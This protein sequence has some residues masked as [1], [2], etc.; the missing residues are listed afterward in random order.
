MEEGL[1]EEEE[2]SR[3]Q[4]RLEKVRLMLANKVSKFDPKARFLRYTFLVKAAKTTNAN[5]LNAVFQ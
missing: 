5:L 3:S 4:Q 2:V 1:R